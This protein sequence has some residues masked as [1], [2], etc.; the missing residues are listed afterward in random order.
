MKREAAR[1]SSVRLVRVRALA[2]PLALSALPLLAFTC[3]APS[4]R[5]APAVAQAETAAGADTG[6]GSETETNGAPRLASEPAGACAIPYTG[7]VAIVLVRSGQAFAN[8]A[9][10]HAS[11]GIVYETDD[12]VIF[13]DGRVITTHLENVGEHLSLLGWAENS[14]QILGAGASQTSR[15]A[16]GQSGQ[17]TTRR[18]G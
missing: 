7:P 1:P 11:V 6:T 13:E 17:R 2:L 15:L 3:P 9:S 14:M 4:S 18:R 16:A 5:T 12:T 10:E 8:A